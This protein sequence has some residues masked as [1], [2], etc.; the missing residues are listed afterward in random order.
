[1]ALFRASFPAAA[2]ALAAVALAA[3]TLAA[4]TLAAVAPASAQTRLAA[5][6]FA[7]RSALLH[8][9]QRC[10]L[11]GEAEL[12]ALA[13]GAALARSALL[14]SGE[15]PARID[16]LDAQAALAAAAR[17]CH[18]P[19]LLRSAQRAQAGFSAW[20]RLSIM[21]FPGQAATWAATR[22]PDAEGWY[23]RQE[24]RY[25]AILGVR[26]GD[27]GPVVALAAPLTARS[28]EP[29]FGLLSF[30]DAA[31]APHSLIAVPARLGQGLAAVSA[32]PAMARQVWAQDRT[33]I[34]TA[35]GRRLAIL[36]FP[37]NAFEGISA[38]DPR[39]AIEVRL[40]RAMGDVGARL[41]FEVGD[42]AAAQAFLAAQP[43]G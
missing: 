30:R 19:A 31:R 16:T 32:S 27:S 18:D 23:L 41:Y 13:A 35:D 9:A 1:M 25:G 7:E 2:G 34:L 42:L 39:E 36:S 15:T 3:V 28:P 8:A 10:P 20:S 37:I 33:V 5:A 40:G 22:R 26:E 14:R 6:T 17:P 29:A 43:A 38:L 24:G 11:L 12:A 4:V 21:L